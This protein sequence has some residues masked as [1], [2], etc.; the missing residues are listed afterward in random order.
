MK[1]RIAAAVAAALCLVVA[2]CE[3]E[4]QESSDQRQTQQQE[5]ILQEGTSE[6]GMANIQTFRE[7]RLMK[8][9]LELRDQEGLSTITYNFAEMTGRHVFLCNSIGY[10]IPYA[11]QFTNPQKIEYRSSYGTAILPQADPNG[12]FSPASAEASWVMCIDPRSRDAKVVY[13]EPRLTVS[14]FPLTADTPVAPVARRAAA[15]NPQ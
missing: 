7:R 6:V 2:A 10:P 14:P 1:K 11:T 8:T 4:P 13:S 3:W 5:K 9:I 15:E 12:L